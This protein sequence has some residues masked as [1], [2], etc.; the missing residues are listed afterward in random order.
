MMRQ[1]RLILIVLVAALVV[2]IVVLFSLKSP[3]STLDNGSLSSPEMVLPEMEVELSTR[4]VKNNRANSSTNRGSRVSADT[5]IETSKSTSPL[6]G[7]RTTNLERERLASL[8]KGESPLSV[9]KKLR[10]AGE[11]NYAREYARL[12]VAENPDSFEALL[13]LG[14][15]LPHEGDERQAIFRRLVET[16]PTSVEALYGL[17]QTL[18]INN[19]P[20][21]AAFYLEA[22]IAEDPSDSTAHY[23]LG[24][25]YEGMGRYDEALVSYKKAFEISQGLVTLA[26]IRAIEAGNPRIKP[27]PSETPE[28]KELPFKGIPPQAPPQ[29]NTPP[30][31][32][33]PSGLERKTGFDESLL[34]ELPS[35]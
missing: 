34:E 31:P 30:I 14:K 18:R 26:H 10:E 12:A 19:Q 23:V 5:V 1:H 32:N 25:S 7:E 28:S 3:Q 6:V 13:L 20:R 2:F 21:E 8:F 9:A 33:A 27:L 16:D 15:L 11:W 35:P 4:S 17:G 29:E 24:K 22:A